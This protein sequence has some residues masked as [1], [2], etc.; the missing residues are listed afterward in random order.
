ML[1]AKSVNVFYIV[2]SLSKNRF[3]ASLFAMS[4]LSMSSRKHNFNFFGR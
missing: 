2:T 3:D 1:S 4:N